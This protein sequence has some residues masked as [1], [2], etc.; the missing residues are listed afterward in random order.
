[1]RRRRHVLQVSTFPFLAVLLCAMG[2]L[3]LLLLVIDRRAKVV[4]RAKAL[5]AIRQMEKEE[6]KEAADHAAEW[7]HRR[8]SLHDQLQQQK[9]ALEAQSASLNRQMTAITHDLQTQGNRGSELEHQIQIQQDSLSRYEKAITSR[10][11]ETAQKKQQS[12]AAQSELV[13]MTADLAKLEQALTDLRAFRKSQQQTYSLVPY[14]GRRG[15]NRR[16][17]Y[18]ECAAGELIV[19]PDRLIVPVM[20]SGAPGILQEIEKRISQIQ[21]ATKS[22][23]SNKDTPYL[24]LLVRPNGILTYYRTLAALKNLKVDFGYEFV[25]AD[26]ILSFPED[27]KAA[28]TQPW[29]DSG[30]PGGNDGRGKRHDVPLS[31]QMTRGSTSRTGP[32]DSAREGNYQV[33]NLANGAGD[34]SSSQPRITANNGQSTVGGAS[35]G[36]NGESATSGNGV[37]GG[38]GISGPGNVG[39]R[40]TLPNDKRKI[41]Q[42]STNTSMNGGPGLEEPPGI[43][44]VRLG[45][46]R[47]RGV[48]FAGKTRFKGLSHDGVANDNMAG[49][50]D[51]DGEEFDQ[52][53]TGGQ[54]SLPRRRN[55]RTF[56]RKESD[57]PKRGDG[58]SS[59]ASGHSPIESSGLSNESSIPS[60]T[61][62]QSSPYQNRT[63]DRVAPGQAGQLGLSQG[64]P[65]MSRGADSQSVQRIQDGPKVDASRQSIFDR[66]LIGRSNSQ[67]P[68]A[69]AAAGPSPEVGMTS[70]QVSNATGPSQ[71]GAPS[72]SSLLPQIGGISTQNLSARSQIDGGNGLSPSPRSPE[73]GNS[74]SRV[75][76]LPLEGGGNAGSSS[77]QP[78][79][80]G[81]NAGSL[82]AHSGFGG[83]GTGPRG[84]QERNSEPPAVVRR[85]VRREWNIFIE[86]KADQVVVYPGDSRISATS[87]VGSAKTNNRPLFETVQQ[88]ITRHQAVIAP[89]EA[90]KNQPLPFPQIRFL[91][92]P[93]GLR[94]YFLAFPELA[95]LRVPMTRENLDADEDVVHHMVGR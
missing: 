33:G 90:K 81:S 93:D 86:C 45:M 70:P 56:G 15:D 36:G 43:S 67:V 30:P 76:P 22:D 28:G 2:S 89:A 25:Q 59:S 49:L 12:E 34:R 1:M 9:E 75:S 21:S 69:A 58:D 16:P 39:E 80:N 48:T 54:V 32:G 60:T 83:Q 42:G 4:M 26:W 10:L 40:L 44:G 78:Q 3:I 63:V 79:G 5:E 37:P 52:D 88:M 31:R 19:H 55:S 51:G 23:S 14:R 8:L 27:E 29:M 84:S 92:R 53:S 85:Y 82:S 74:A 47:P 57:S 95:P 6:E 73:E 65:V 46:A 11:H 66:S 91:V 68:P 64:I 35:T 18:L 7:E 24:L 20:D 71:L 94:T 61:F 87:L 50:S 17:I 41:G 77:T 38:S 13:Q 62:S 72:P